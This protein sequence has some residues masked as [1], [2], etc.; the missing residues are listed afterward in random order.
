V[1]SQDFKKRY[2]LRVGG[3]RFDLSPSVMPVEQ[4]KRWLPCSEAVVRP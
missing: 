4:A 1:C 2:S 3:C